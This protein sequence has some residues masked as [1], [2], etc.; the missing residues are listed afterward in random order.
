MD[1][2]TLIVDDGSSHRPLKTGEQ[3]TQLKGHGVRQS[4]TKTITDND[5]VSSGNVVYF[6]LENKLNLNSQWNDFLSFQLRMYV[7]FEPGLPT[8]TFCWNWEKDRNAMKNY[9]IRFDVIFFKKPEYYI[10]YSSE[11]PQRIA[12]SSRPQPITIPYFIDAFSYP[13]NFRQD[14]S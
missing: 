11:N 14:I 7:D 12:I 5:W 3:I 9:N 8:Y 1:K 2:F 10:D 13:A 4:F 6:S